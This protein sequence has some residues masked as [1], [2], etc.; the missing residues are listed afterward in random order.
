MK[1]TVKKKAAAAKK[2]KRVARKRKKVKLPPPR[3]VVPSD[4]DDRDLP[5]PAR[6]FDKQR[7]AVAGRFSYYPHKSMI[8]EV[9]R[10]EGAVIVEAINKKLDILIVESSGNATKI[11]QA[12][13]LNAAGASIRIVADLTDLWST[14]QISIKEVLTTPECIGHFADIVEQSWLVGD[15][16]PVVSEDFS[17]CTLSSPG[18][19]ACLTGVEFVDCD[20]SKA[21]LERVDLGGYDHRP[22]RC[23][24]ARANFNDCNLREAVDCQ[25]D[26]AKGSRVE[27]ADATHCTLHKVK[28]KDSILSGLEDCR[29][30]DC[31]FDGVEVESYSNDFCLGSTT[32]KNSR[33]AGIKAREDRRPQ[34][35]DGCQ[36][37][38]VEFK[39]GSFHRGLV[40]NDCQLTN[41][42]FTD[43]AIS[44]LSF[45]GCTLADCTFSRCTIT[46]VHFDDSKLKN[47][48]VSGGEIRVATATAAQ[49]AQLAGV[50]QNVVRDP[51][52]FKQIKALATAFRAAGG[53]TIDVDVQ[54]TDGH[55]V[56]MYA[57]KSW[58]SDFS[59]SEKK[60][61]G[62]AEDF[63]LRATGRVGFPISDYQKAFIGLFCAVPVASVDHETLKTTSSKCS[64]KGKDLKQL[65]VQ[66]IYEANGI[67]PPSEDDLKESQQKR[68]KDKATT[69]DAVRQELAAGQVRQINK[70]SP[71]ELAAASP[72]KK[73]QLAGIDLKGVKLPG[74]ELGQSDFS[75]ADLSGSKLNKAGLSKADLS[76]ANLKKANLANANLKEANLSGADLSEAKL[77]KV[78]LQGAQLSG[79]ILTGASLA[80]TDLSGV[81]LSSA[82]L[83]GVN[84]NSAIY[85]EKT[86]LPKSVTKALM[87]KMRWSG[88]GLPPHKRKQNKKV[89]GP[90]DFEHFMARLNE[91]TDSSR[92]SKSL[93]MLKADAFQLFSEVTDDAMIGVVKSQTDA[94]LVYSCKLNSDGEFTCCTQNLNSCGGLRGA[95]CKHILVLVVGLAKSGALDPAVVDEWVNGSKQKNPSLDKDQMGEILLKYKGAEAGEID[96]RPTETVPEDFFAF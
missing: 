12:K 24:F 30:E 21:T 85:N 19:T 2:V 53:L 74:V 58:A 27:I 82:K 61:G 80:N 71:Q 34:V 20:F 17:K 44:S 89:S 93:K 22:T 90:I 37:E 59:W 88:G 10:R 56:R 92:L 60:K 75:H 62:R 23:N 41:I 39:R 50:A 69:R 18:R 94:K 32:V 13:K 6:L 29:I 26:G 77:G 45:S 68:R 65:V 81:D 72:L 52:R 47:C 43:L 79:A 46:Q 66:A 42:K 33:F 55:E 38:N 36:L 96:W 49:A 84:L 25:F 11:K 64:V 63:S 78:S 7:I 28:F 87:E 95:I 1:K 40:F 8:T 86:Q 48:K 15:T 57:N 9:L 16:H 70:R 73:M 51:S 76:G 91:I 35:F 4:A 14:S 31:T 67:E 3:A 5:L 54:T 83:D